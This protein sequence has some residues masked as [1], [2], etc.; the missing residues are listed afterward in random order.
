M[1]WSEGVD[2]TFMS[3]S[4]SH[5]DVV[6][7]G[8]EGASPWRATGFYGHPNTSK[9][10]ISWELLETLKNQSTLPCVVFSDFNEIKHPKEKLGWLD[11]DADQ[12]GNFKEC[13]GRFA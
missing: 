1:I 9:R 13:L 5:I 10:H 2:V 3:C 4:H 7:H 11:R 8:E 6:V 12:M